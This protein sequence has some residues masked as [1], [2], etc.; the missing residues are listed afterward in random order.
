MAQAQACCS[1][2]RSCLHRL[3]HA[4]LASQHRLA[5]T[6]HT[7]SVI[8]AARGRKKAAELTDTD[9]EQPSSSSPA[10]S[11]AAAQP[12]AKRRQKKEA[13]P[14]EELEQLQVSSSAVA[15]TPK[16]AAA[17]AAAAEALDLHAHVPKDDAFASISRWVAFSD[18]HVNRRTL[19][20]CLKVLQRVHEEAAQRKAGILFLGKQLL[21]CSLGLC[22]DG[23]SMW[24]LVASPD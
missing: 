5:I 15:A 12:A 21:S 14:A 18:L 9:S 16:P 20:T 7:S 10:A 11:P 6:L 17:R 2:A 8:C 23:A 19:K 3:G 24:H 4:A 13:V 1:L 22:T